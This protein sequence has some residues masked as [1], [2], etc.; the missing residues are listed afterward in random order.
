MRY[1]NI[2]I[3]SFTNNNGDSFPIKD[4]RPIPSEPI[5]FSVVPVGDVDI[6]EIASRKNVY[7]DLAE[8]QSYRIFDANV[9]E[10]VE[11]EFDASKLSEISIPL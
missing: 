5:S 6:D 7:G 11:N 9:V 3:I 2:D 4:I 10:L 8:D 1:N